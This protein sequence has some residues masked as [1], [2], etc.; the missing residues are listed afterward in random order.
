MEEAQLFYKLCTLDRFRQMLVNKSIWV[1]SVLEFNDCME[2]MCSYSDADIN[3]QNLSKQSQRLNFE[4]E[5][6]RELFLDRVESLRQA[7]RRREYFSDYGALCL[8]TNIT[9]STMWGHYADGGRGIAI[10]LTKADDPLVKGLGPYRIRYSDENNVLSSDPTDK[11]IIDTLCTKSSEWEYE[12]EWRFL[13][14]G[15]TNKMGS[16]Y[17]FFPDNIKQ[18]VFGPRCD[19]EEAKGIFEYV[20]VHFPHCEMH[21]VYP[22]SNSFRLRLVPVNTRFDLTDIHWMNSKEGDDFI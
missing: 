4:D 18:I 11:E 3:R 10:A 8:T 12:E 16:H 14:R 21:M 1:S 13:F 20:K 22:K 5:V 15:F 19:S 2:A 9:S 7:K 6:R 17:D